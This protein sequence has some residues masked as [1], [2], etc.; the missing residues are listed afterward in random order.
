MP[1]LQNWMF[2]DKI[3]FKTHDVFK[4][5]VDTTWNAVITHN[6]KNNCTKCEHSISHKMLAIT[7][8]CSNPACDGKCLVEYKAYKCPKRDVYIIMRLNEH[9]EELKEEKKI[10]TKR[11]IIP[12]V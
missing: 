11:G 1:K 4:S 12:R 2:Y 6:N 3:Q 10:P 5:Y 7:M 8:T 9:D